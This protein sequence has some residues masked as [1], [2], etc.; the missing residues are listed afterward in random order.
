MLPFPL[1]KHCRVLA[2]C[3]F[4]SVFAT[5]KLAGLQHLGRI[6]AK[7]QRYGSPKNGHSEANHLA[8]AGCQS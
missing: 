8:I 7:R 3:G 4:A 1:Q 6:A 5:P 2:N